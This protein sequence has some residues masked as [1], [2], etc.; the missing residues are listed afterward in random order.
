MKWKLKKNILN[1]RSLLGPYYSYSYELFD[2]LKKREDGETAPNICLY[3]DL[4]TTAQ[5]E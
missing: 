5:L 3:V 4:I 1:C 2:S